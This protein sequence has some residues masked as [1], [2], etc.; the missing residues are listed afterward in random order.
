LHH[1]PVDAQTDPAQTPWLTT[2]RVWYAGQRLPMEIA[3]P[4][5]LWHRDGEEPL[6][7][8][9]CGSRDPSG[10]RDPFALFSTHDHVS[11]QHISAW[12]V[13]RW[14]IALTFQEARA[15][16]G[17]GDAAPLERPG[18]PSHD[19]L[20]PRPLQPRPAP[21]SPALPTHLPPRQAAWYTKQEP[22]F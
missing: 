10:E 17:L 8:R 9:W 22:T 7:I 5:A 12:Y 6:P 13:S 16:L 11:L 14:P 21:G 4:I 20:P 3:T 18:S 2:E 1:E 15:H 19:A